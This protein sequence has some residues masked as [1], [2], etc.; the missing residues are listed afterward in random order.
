MDI[1]KIHRDVK[2][3]DCKNM[4]FLKDEIEWIIKEKIIDMYSNEEKVR[5]WVLNELQDIARFINFYINIWVMWMW[6]KITIQYS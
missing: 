1:S 3:I 5:Q 6:N 2:I 4:N